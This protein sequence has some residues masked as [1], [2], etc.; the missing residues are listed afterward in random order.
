MLIGFGVVLLVAGAVLSFAVDVTF[1]GLD[2]IGVGWFVL[3]VG[4]LAVLAGVIR[5]AVS[6]VVRRMGRPGPDGVSDRDLLEDS[7]GG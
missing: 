5:G 3:V 2:R 7:S 4:A 6:D 1:D